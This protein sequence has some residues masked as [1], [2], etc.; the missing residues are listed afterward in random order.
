MLAL[1]LSLQIL[2]VAFLLLHDWVPLGPL[3]DTRAVRAANPGSKV[4][5]GTLIS[6]IP[7]VIALFFSIEHQHTGYPHWLFTFLWIAYA[8]LFVG[9]IQAWWFP[10]F[11]GAKPE[12]IERY[13]QMFGATHAFLPPRNGIRINTLHIFLHL[14]TLLTLLTL[15]VLT[16]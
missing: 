10:F 8:L 14:A 13:D 2:H 5:L 6:S 7:F 9:E 1:L 4:L 16:L 3:N 12:L 11:F 15:A